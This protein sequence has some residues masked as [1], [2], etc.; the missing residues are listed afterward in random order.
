MRKID[1]ERKKF[2]FSSFRDQNRAVSPAVKQRQARYDSARPGQ[3]RYDSREAAPDQIRPDKPDN[4]NQAAAQTMIIFLD[5]TIA[6]PD[7][8]ADP[9]QPAVKQHQTR[10]DKTRQNIPN[11][12]AMKQGQ[13][14]Q[15]K[16]ANS[17]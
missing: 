8:P 12:L 7:K 17:V 13:T 14:N 1:L 6:K 5:A 9:N 4:P 16:P 3:T 10:P 15:H 2:R 11:Q